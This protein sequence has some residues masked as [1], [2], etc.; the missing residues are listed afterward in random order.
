MDIPDSVEDKK[1]HE[2]VDITP[3]DQLRRETE[4]WSHFQLN[5]GDKELD[6]Q[7]L[8]TIPKRSHQ[9]RVTNPILGTQQLACIKDITPTSANIMRLVSAILSVPKSHI[10][11]VTVLANL[12]A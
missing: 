9:N 1:H 11:I 7:S 3:E 6:I 4:E 10:H 12:S 2:E 5:R 8:N